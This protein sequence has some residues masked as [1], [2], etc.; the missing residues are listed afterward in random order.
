MLKSRPGIPRAASPF[1]YMS[2]NIR[3][4]VWTENENVAVP[5]LMLMEVLCR[6]PGPTLPHSR[7]SARQ[8]C[9]HS[10]PDPKPA[11]MFSLL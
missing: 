7:V 11:E 8:N 4:G 3:E 5:F 2:W 10:R 9:S 6:T 1:S